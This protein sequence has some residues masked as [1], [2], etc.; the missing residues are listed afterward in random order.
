MKRHIIRQML[1]EW[2]ENIWLLLGLI[3]VCTAVAVLA[4]TLWVENKGWFEPKGFNPENVLVADMSVIDSTSRQYVDLGEKGIQADM[5]NHKAIVERIRQSPNVEKVGYGINALPYTMNFYGVGLFRADIAK[6]TLLV[7]G[8]LRQVSPEVAEVLELQSVTG[9]SPRELADLLSNDMLLIGQPLGE[10]YESYA[11]VTEHQL[12]FTFDSISRFKVGDR[13]NIIKRSEF[14]SSEMAGTIVKRFDERGGDGLFETLMI[15]TKPGCADKFWEEFAKTADMRH[16]GNSVAR[17]LK[18]L[19]SMARIVNAEQ[20]ASIR[21]SLLIVI[22]FIAL[23]ILGLMGTFWFRV[24]Q[25]SGEIALRKIC[26]ATSGDI[27]RRIIG[28][29]MILLAGAVAVAFGLLYL[30]TEKV[31]ETE[32]PVSVSLMAVVTLVTGLLVAAGI[33]LSIWYPAYRAMHI[34]PALAVK[35]E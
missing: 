1:N 31:I 13:I 33:V 35:V 4:L 2:R 25:R 8:N 27:F 16:I 9:K 14:E 3:I 12:S 24:Q 34:E 5:R 18:S 17:N 26:G 15:K 10:K 21:L 6:D 7:M 11:D 22:V 19:D 28:E 32:E 23:I 20:L 30:I 29:A